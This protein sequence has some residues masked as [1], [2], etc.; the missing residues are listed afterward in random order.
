MDKQLPQ[1]EKLCCWIYSQILGDSSKMKKRRGGT[2]ED[3]GDTETRQMTMHNWKESMRAKY[4]LVEI[5]IVVGR[6][7]RAQLLL[8]SS[9]LISRGPW[10]GRHHRRKQSE[11][12]SGTPVLLF[13]RRH[14][15]NPADPARRHTS[16]HMVILSAAAGQMTPSSPA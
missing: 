9:G 12:Q 16:R 4:L 8:F 3:G 7:L 13:S 5:C 10:N 14:H 15:S 2:D 11:R 1:Q 6:Q